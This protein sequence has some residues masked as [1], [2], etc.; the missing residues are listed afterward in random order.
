M[1]RITLL[2]TA[3]AL[4]V[5]MSL[6]VGSSMAYFTTYATARGGYQ[7]VLG[8]QT[9]ITEDYDN[10]KKTIVVSNT[11]SVPVYVRVKAFAGNSITL[12]YSGSTKWTYN[13]SDQYWYYSD[14][15]PVGGSTESLVVSIEFDR[16]KVSSDFNV[17]VV[18]ECTPVLYDASGSPYADWSLSTKTGEEGAQ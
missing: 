16:S 10:W 12:N 11:G 9:K 13:N 18:Q 17:I 14:I 6:S 3:F 15:V 4:V 8:H 2:L 7:I 1:K 5:T